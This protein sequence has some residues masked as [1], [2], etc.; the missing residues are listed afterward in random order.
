MGDRCR[1][2]ATVPLFFHVWVK[3]GGGEGRAFVEATRLSIINMMMMGLC[4]VT[5]HPR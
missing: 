5:Y 1:G 3:G 4:A 2:A